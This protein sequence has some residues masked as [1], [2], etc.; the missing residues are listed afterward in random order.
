MLKPIFTVLAVLCATL[1]VSAQVAMDLTLNRSLYMQYEPIY[2]CVTLRNDSGRPLLFG[3][4]AELQGY[5]LFEV[6]DQRGRPIPKRP[7]ADLTVTGLVLEPGQIRRLIVP[8]NRYYQLD[9]VGFFRVHAYVSHSLLPS[10]FKS[11]DLKFNIEPGVTL[12]TKSVGLPDLNNS[13]SPGVA[14]ERSYSLRSL[15]DTTTKAYYLVIEDD[16]LVHA[17]IRVGQAIG[18]EKFTAEVDMLSRVHLLIPV[19]PK[20][21]HYLAFDTNG[22]KFADEYRKT[23]GTIPMLMRDP[24]SGIISLIGGETAQVGIDYTDPEAGLVRVDEL[25]GIETEEIAPTPDAPANKGLVDL[26]KDL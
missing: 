17:V 24:N 9:K 16:K 14:Q 7:G 19:S 18:Y 3:K 23:V 11:P 6:T 10:E 12:W 13:D 1:T 8:I 2:A 5:L 15:V 21:F 26:G 22:K 20:V 4:R 25:D